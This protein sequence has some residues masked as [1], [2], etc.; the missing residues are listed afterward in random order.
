V[1]NE[2][3]TIVGMVGDVKYGGLDLTA[4]PEIYMPH[5]QHPVDSLTVAVRTAG[6]PLAAVPTVRT[7][8]AAIDRELPIADIHTM[9]EVVGRSIAERRFTMLLLASF[10]AVAVLLAAI[11]VYGVLAYLIGQRTQ[12]IGVRLALGAAPDDVV[13]LFLREGT[14]LAGVGLVAG[15]AGA[16]A[17]TRALSTLLFGVTTTDPVT[18]AGVA[19]AVGLVALVASYIPAKRASRV[20]PMSALRMD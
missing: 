17:A 3:K 14:T 8:L 9:D 6:D 15:V 20:D 7:E 13:R 10:A 4:P 5:A 11:G 1:R 12:E 18:F 16:L 19:G 2:Q